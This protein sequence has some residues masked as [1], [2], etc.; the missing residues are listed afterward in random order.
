MPEVSFP[1]A[2]QLMRRVMRMCGVAAADSDGDHLS[3]E[4]DD[5]ALARVYYMQDRVPSNFRPRRP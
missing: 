3:D 1:D 2:R 5:E 4:Y